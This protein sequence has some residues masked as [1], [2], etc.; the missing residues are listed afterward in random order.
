[1]LWA[2]TL[3]TVTPLGATVWQIPKAGHY[4][5]LGLLREGG[6]DPPGRGGEATHPLLVLPHQGGR[7]ARKV[8]FWGSWGAHPVRGTRKPGGE[9]PPTLLATL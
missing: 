9:S 3:V 8:G 7:S 1:M 4:V 2:G 6:S 5:S